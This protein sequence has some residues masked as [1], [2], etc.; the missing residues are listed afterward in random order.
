M[1]EPVEPVR[2]G[3]RRLQQLATL[4]ASSCVSLSSTV[5]TAPVIAASGVRRS[6]DTGAEERAAKPLALFADRRCP[7]LLGQGRAVDG[8]GLS[9]ASSA[10]ASR[11]ARMVS[12]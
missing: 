4:G 2:L 12:R 7:R 11:V 8:E 9:A 6:C 10:S 3:A 5:L 1:D